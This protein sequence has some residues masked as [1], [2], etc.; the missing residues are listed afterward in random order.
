[1]PR[2]FGTTNAAPYAVAPPVG[3]EGDMYFNT[4]SDTLWLSDGTQWIQIQSGGFPEYGARARRNVDQAIG[5]ATSTVVMTTIMTEV[6]P[7]ATWYDGASGGLKVPAGAGGRYLLAAHCRWE[8]G[9]VTNS[10]LIIFV[11]GIPV[12]RDAPNQTSKQYFEQHC[13]C[14]WTLNAGDV[15]TLGANHQTGGNKNI[16][17]IYPGGGTDPAGPILEVWKIDSKGDKGDKGDT[18]QHGGPVPIGG[19]PFQVLTKNSTTDGDTQWRTPPAAI[20]NP[21]WVTRTLMNGW[22]NYGGQFQPFGMTRRNGVVFFGGLIYRS[23]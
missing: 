6:T 11:N 2:S 5:S 21:T 18:G 4:T 9:L 22:S 17:T 23:S 14:A 19:K 7:G 12:V 20:G 15:V 10:A 16:S 13:A 1:M 3:A 8:A